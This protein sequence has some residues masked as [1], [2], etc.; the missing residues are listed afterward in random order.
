[1]DVY[2]CNQKTYSQIQEDLKPFQIVNFNKFHKGIVQKF[3]H[4]ASMSL[5]NYVVLRNQIYRRCY[6]EHVGFKMFMDAILL[7]LMR[8]V[9]LPD[10]ELFVNLGDWPLMRLNE[11]ETYPIFSWCGSLHSMDIVMPT[12]ELTESSLE[13]MGRVT[14]DMLSVQGNI[15]LPWQEKIPKA[16]WR[17]RDSSRERLKLIDI[18]RKHLDLFNVSLTNFFFFRDEEETYGPK[19]KHISF[20]KFFDYKY[21]INLDGTVAAYRFPYLL[22]GD[23]LVFKQNSVYYEF[24]YNDLKPWVHYVPF[25]QDLSDLVE[26]IQWAMKHEDEALKIIQN[27]REYA[28]EH[29]L[30][31]D[32]FCYHAVLFNEWS[33]RIVSP[34]KIR[35]NMDYVPQQDSKHSCKCGKNENTESHDEL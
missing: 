26:Q 21:Q 24:F 9:H 1:M 4:S 14:L 32:I 18:A 19:E 10:M 15:D 30:P 5:C 25:K 22:A 20:F 2:G 34:V 31:R 16:F 12:Y 29:L 3:N 11:K 8:K 27:A 23:A 13:C 33:K 28:N 17:G 35:R 7:S 6:G